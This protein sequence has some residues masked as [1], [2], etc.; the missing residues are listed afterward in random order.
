MDGRTPPPRR[1]GT[2]LLVRRPLLYVAALLVLVTN[3]HV[4]KAVWPGMVTGKLSDFA[5]LFAFAIF[6]GTVLP[7][8]I[9]CAGAGAFFIWWKSPGSQPVIDALPWG[10]GRVVDWTDLLA[11]M[12]LV[13][14]FR[15]LPPPPAR[16]RM[17]FAI[18]VLSFVAFAATST[19]HV[20]IIVAHDDP[21][22]TI[23]TCS[24]RAEVLARF[25]RAPF[26]HVYS[27]DN[28]EF[29]LSIDVPEIPNTHGTF[30]YV[31]VDDDGVVSLESMQIFTASA[32]DERASETAL[33]RKL[34]SCLSRCGP[35]AAQR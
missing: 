18:A 2:S 23:E 31:T 13:P 27:P 9:A 32:V 19:A 25:S 29:Q 33:R 34:A 8:N 11:L 16:A 28:R 24:T 5:G 20:T 1:A 35:R 26:D 4:L 7:R 15:L 30:A 6:L 3:D 22:R 14:A 12:V 21:L 17:P 10:A